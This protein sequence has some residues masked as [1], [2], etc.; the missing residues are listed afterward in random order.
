MFIGERVD[1]FYMSMKQQTEYTN[2]QKTSRSQKKVFYNRQI[3]LTIHHSLKKSIKKK[4]RKNFS[5]SIIGLVFSH[6]Q[7][8]L[9]CFRTELNQIW[10]NGG[11][12]VYTEE[13]A[14]KQQKNRKKMLNLLKF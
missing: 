4:D 11:E 3:L 12:G 1:L 8:D 9:H 2:N 5:S 14:T 13:T 6:V 7:I 10:I